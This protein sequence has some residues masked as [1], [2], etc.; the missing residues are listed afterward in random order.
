M[1]LHVILFWIALAVREIFYTLPFKLSHRKKITI[2]KLR[3]RRPEP[4]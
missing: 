3:A 4:S 1:L 2:P